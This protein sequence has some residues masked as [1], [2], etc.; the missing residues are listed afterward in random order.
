MARSPRFPGCRYGAFAL[1]GVLRERMQPRERLLGMGAA[2]TA[3][4]GGHAMALAAP[5]LPLGWLAGARVLRRRRVLVVTD[6]RLLVLGPLRPEIN[7]ASVRWNAEI[8]MARVAVV[9]VG[10]S[11]FRFEAGPDSF[12]A[13]LRGRWVG[14][15]LSTVGPASPGMGEAR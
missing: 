3:G 4:P 15:E 2:D 7:A 8:P 10:S 14:A 11:R 13:R 1:R 12:E 9:P 5:L 6:R